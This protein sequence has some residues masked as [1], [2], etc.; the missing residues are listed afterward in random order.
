[1]S[2]RQQARQAQANLRRLTQNDG[3][4]RLQ[5]ALQRLGIGALQPRQLRL[6]RI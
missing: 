4:Q 2:S 6:R 3:L 5:R 1:M